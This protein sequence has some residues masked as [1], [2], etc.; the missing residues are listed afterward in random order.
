M[1]RFNLF[2]ERLFLKPKYTIG[3]IHFDGKLFCNTLEDTVRDLNKDG[4]LEDYGEM[5]IYGET[6]IPYG[7]YKV[8]V[9]YSPKLKRELPLILDVKHFTGIRI[10]KVRSAAGTLGCVG[11]GKNTSPGILT[12]G[13]YFEKKLTALLKEKIA[14]GI[15]CYINIV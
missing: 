14:A 6:A 3:V 1:E 13:E 8:I 10:H 7:V 11:V 15:E 12:D 2:L 4:D 5:K 9:N